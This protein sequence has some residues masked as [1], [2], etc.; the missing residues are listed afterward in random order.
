[1]FLS[2]RENRKS[3]SIINGAISEL[4]KLFPSNTLKTYTVD[5]GKELACY[6]KVEVELNIPAYF[7]D[8]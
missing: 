1:M 7:T 4:C 5:R 8:A 6:C 3:L 2:D